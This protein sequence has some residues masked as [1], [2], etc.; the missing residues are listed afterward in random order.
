MPN[1]G[2]VDNVYLVINGRKATDQEKDIYTKRTW[3]APDG[4]Y[5]GKV[6]IDL[7]NLQKFLSEAGTTDSEKVRKIKEIVN[8]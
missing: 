2:D 8:G 4:L 7:K 5:Y 6:N 3:S 1:S